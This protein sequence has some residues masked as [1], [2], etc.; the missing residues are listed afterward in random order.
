MNIEK[1]IQ[2]RIDTLGQELANKKVS[3]PKQETEVIELFE[4]LITGIAEKSFND[5][6]GCHGEMTLLLKDPSDDSVKIAIAPIGEFLVSRDSKDV[7]FDTIIPKIIDELEGQD[8]QVLAIATATEAWKRE[9]HKDEVSTMEDVEKLKRTEVLIVNFE[10]ESGMKIYMSEIIRSSDG[11]P[12]VGPLK[13]QGGGQPG[14]R[15]SNLL[16][17]RKKIFINNQN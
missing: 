8:L 4:R 7:L 15:F 17:S 10:T 2:T 9:A 12:V 6:H 16:K 5:I 13:Y 14:G 3:T 1:D 11:V